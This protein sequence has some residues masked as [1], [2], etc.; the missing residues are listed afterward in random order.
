MAAPKRAPVTAR[1]VQGFQSFRL[2]GP[3]MEHLHT[4]GTERERAG[5]RQL[6]YEQYATWWRLY[7][8]SPIV[9]SLRG[10]PQATPLAKVPARFG[11][12]PT[13]LGALS[14]AGQVFD[15]ALLQEVIAALGQ[16]LPVPAVA[17]ERAARQALTA[18]EGSLLPALPTMA[19]ARWQDAPHRAAKRPVACEVLRQIPVAVTVTAGQAS[20]RTPGRRL[21]QPGGC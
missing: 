7:F 3:L 16:R 21:V 5:N 17:T 18:V 19:W 6:C 13:S 15:A 9:T 11:V 1:D 14:E 8:F 4:A 12:G 2:L 10:L 20:E